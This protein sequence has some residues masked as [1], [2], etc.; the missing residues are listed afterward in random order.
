MSP[1][2]AQ[3]AGFNATMGVQAD[4]VTETFF[5]VYAEIKKGKHP[6]SKKWGGLQIELTGGK[7]LAKS[8]SSIIMYPSN[9]KADPVQIRVNGYGTKDAYE[10][11]FSDAFYYDKDRFVSFDQIQRGWEIVEKIKKASKRKFGKQLLIYKK[12]SYP[13]DISHKS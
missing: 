13:Q 2:L 9:R 3:Y 8:D 10:Q 6:L 4:S 11:I 1:V 5:K 12:G 7:A